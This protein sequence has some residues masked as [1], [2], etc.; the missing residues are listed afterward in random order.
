MDIITTPTPKRAPP[1]NSLI[2]PA[3]AWFGEQRGVSQP[4]P[5]MQYDDTLPML[6]VALYLNGQPY[7]VPDGA[8][9]NIRMDKRDGHHVYNEAYGLSDDRKTVYVE[10]T[11]QMTTGAGEFPAILEL[12]VGGNSAGTSILPLRIAKNPVPEDAV[13]STDEYKKIQR[14]AEEVEQAAQVVVD[15][16]E[17]LQWLKEN[18]QVVIDVSENADNI[19]TV[20]ENAANINAVA[21]NAANINTVVSEMEAIKAAP[22]A[23]SNAA[24]SATQAGASA[25][26]SKSWAVGGTGTRDGEDTNNAKY[27]AEQAQQVAQGAMGWYATPQALQSAHPTGQNGQWA[28]VGTTDTIW[29]WD[30][31]T[32]AWVDSGSNMDLSQYYTKTEADARFGTVQQVQQAQATANAAA[33]IEKIWENPSPTAEYAA[34]TISVPGLAAYDMIII[35]T[36][37]NGTLPYAY[38]PPTMAPKMG[39]N[40]ISVT[41]YQGTFTRGFTVNFAAQTIAI[42]DAYTGGVDNRYLVPALIFGIKF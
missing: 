16:A 27:W 9:L 31:D 30:R 13:E 33:V 11:L 19:S 24:D 37:A 10:V 7:T 29:I 2:L 36:N 15:N 1:E 28:I 40:E 22:T 34:Q 4:V 17:T 18:E 25:T 12:V 3:S 32:S 35:F 39:A 26:L 8:A 5:L 14:I 42:G 38:N 41:S 21:E 20:A 6:A 23:A